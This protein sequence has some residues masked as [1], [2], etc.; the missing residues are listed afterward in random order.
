MPTGRSGKSRV[1]MNLASNWPVLKNA[2][3]EWTRDKIP[4]LGAALAFYSVLSIAPLLI[5]AIAV[6]GL[7]FGEQAASGQL[8]AQIRELVGEE[9]AGAVKE[10][11]AN[12]HKPRG[13]IVAT[14]VGVVTLL[15]A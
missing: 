13:G 7:V 11:L 14:V 6:A 4:Q 10:M 3:Q 1:P 5:I 15:I 12:A 9:G 8:D 2:A